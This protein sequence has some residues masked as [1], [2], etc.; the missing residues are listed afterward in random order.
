MPPL[1]V[2]K[3]QGQKHYLHAWRHQEYHHTRKRASQKP[4][5]SAQRESC[6]SKFRQ[7]PAPSLEEGERAVG[8][9]QQ[10]AEEAWGGHDAVQ[11][12]QGLAGMALLVVL[13]AE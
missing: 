2:R 7:N 9:P 1:G 5:H 10:E 11:A 8:Q 13:K 12:Q 6:S 3:W 4:H